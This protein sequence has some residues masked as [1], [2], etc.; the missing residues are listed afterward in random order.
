MNKLVKRIIGSVL[1]KQRLVGDNPNWTEVLGLVAAVINSQHGCKKDDVLSYKAVYGQ[2]VDHKVP[3]SKEEA[4]WCWTLP[5][6]LKVTNNTEFSNYVSANHYLDDNSA[7][8]DEDDD[9]Y[10]SDETL[11]DDERD[12]VTDETF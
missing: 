12:E 5:Q 7:A 6:L 4:R 8:D 11:P 9:G 3:C 10:F 2:Q 1:T